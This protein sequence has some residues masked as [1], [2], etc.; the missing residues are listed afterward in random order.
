[1]VV[2]FEVEMRYSVINNSVETVET[3]CYHYNLLFSIYQHITIV[4]G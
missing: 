2:H 1:M 4:E 3:L